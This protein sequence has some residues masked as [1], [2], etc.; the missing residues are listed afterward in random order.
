MWASGNFSC[1]VILE[2]HDTYPLRILYDMNEVSMEPLVSRSDVIVCFKDE[3]SLF[4]QF[5]NR[6]DQYLVYGYRRSEVH[7][8][9]VFSVIHIFYMLCRVMSVPGYIPD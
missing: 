3:L 4:Y 7:Y 6:L 9:L 1:F 5:F 8:F 2:R